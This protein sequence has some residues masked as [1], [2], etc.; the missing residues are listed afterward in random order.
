MP[1]KSNQNNQ[2]QKKSQT[3][4]NVVT[5]PPEDFYSSFYEKQSTCSA[6]PELIKSKSYKEDS[7]TSTKNKKSI[8]LFL[9][10]MKTQ[11]SNI[12][13]LTN[14]YHLR[15]FQINF[16]NSSQARQMNFFYVERIN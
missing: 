6:I 12:T 15:Q 5:L 7:E 2:K 4:S 11:R 8:I 16:L 1:K 13:K 10:Q 14:F 3:K 9:P